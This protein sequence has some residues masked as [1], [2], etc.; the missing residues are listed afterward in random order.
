MIIHFVDLQ[1]QYQSIKPDIDKAVRR[2]ITSGMYIMGPEVQ[3]F[4]QE[5]TSYLKVKHAIGVASGTDA[6]HLSLLACGI[7]PGDEVI[8]TPFTT[9]ATTEVIKHC[10][11][12]PAFVD[13]DPQTYN[14][15]PSKIKNK[16]SRRTKAIIPVHLFGNPCDMD[17]IMVIARKHNL[18]VIED[19]A[20]ALG[21]EYQGSKAGTLGDIGCLSFF[22]ANNLG[23]YGDGGMVVTNDELVAQRVRT[24]RLHGSP[25][26]YRY[27]MDGFNSRLDAIQAAILRVK[28]GYLGQWITARNAVAI[29]YDRLL[30]NVEGI[31]VPFKQPGNRHSYNYYTIC[32]KGGK[33]MRD[34]LRDHLKQ[35]G[36][37]TV[38]FYPVS[39]HLQEVYSHMKFKKNEFPVSEWAQDRLLSL[40]IYPELAPQQGDYIVDEIKSFLAGPK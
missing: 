27:T 39:M 24:L 25:E 6:L 9:A 32:V 13:I 15:E 2:V 26:P 11:A 17:Q 20:Q 35:K 8:T 7:K 30:E 1:S 34:G 10:D 12:T 38:T 36:V 16:V 4:E 31:D 14:I 28:L 29:N 21:T 37:H 5:M 19:C 33:E 22:P 18:K 40:P 23:A 3:S